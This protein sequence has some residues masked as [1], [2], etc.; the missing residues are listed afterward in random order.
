MTDLYNMTQT[1]AST[2]DQWIN[3]WKLDEYEVETL[4]ALESS[5]SGGKTK[6]ELLW[7]ENLVNLAKKSMQHSV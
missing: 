7:K 3:Q 6:N 2:L 1:T 5:P 4:M